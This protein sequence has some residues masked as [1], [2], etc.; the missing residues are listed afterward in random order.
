MG[1]KMTI[2][3]R[4]DLP[5]FSAH[6]VGDDDVYQDI[7]IVD[8]VDLKEDLNDYVEVSNNGI[9]IYYLNKDAIKDAVMIPG[10]LLVTAV[11]G[12]MFSVRNSNSIVEIKSIIHNKQMK[13]LC[14]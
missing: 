3:I 14:S 2:Y 12:S 13:E 1:H 10:E 11:N 7:Q 8:M 5:S 4:I 6:I 9:S